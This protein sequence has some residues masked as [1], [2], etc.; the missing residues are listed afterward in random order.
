MKNNHVYLASASPRRRQLLEQIGISYEVI[1]PDVDESKLDDIDPQAYT[2][3]I[4]IAKAQFAK[5]ILE[6]EKLESF[7]II[8][9]DTAVVFEH[10]IL[11]KPQ[12]KS[13]AIYML[14]QLSDRTHNVY[15]SVCVIG[16]TEPQVITQISEVTFKQ[17]SKKEIEGYW[18][19]GEPTDKAGGYGIQGLGAKFV[20]HLSGSYSGVMGLP[21]YELLILLDNTNYE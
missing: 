7:P 18:S 9:A 20:K 3:R 10:Q 14:N 16:T 17:I 19:T 2:Q 1:K 11:G 13:N 6:D 5:R 15:S 8:A 4:A 21:L 12:N